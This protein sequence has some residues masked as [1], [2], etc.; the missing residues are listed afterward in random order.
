MNNVDNDSDT[1]MENIRK[2]LLLSFQNELTGFTVS[3][4]NYNGGT[5]VGKLFVE[6]NGIKQYR[7]I[8]IRQLVEIRKLTGQVGWPDQS[9][10]DC[11]VGI[12]VYDLVRYYNKAKVHK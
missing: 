1:N 6:K 12:V 3:M 9:D 7:S 8:P 11:L 4:S 5:I 2:M 10:C